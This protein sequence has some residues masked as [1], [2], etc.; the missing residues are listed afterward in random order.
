MIVSDVIY[1]WFR[2]K[3]VFWLDALLDF[4]DPDIT[5][6]SRGI[7]WKK[8]GDKYEIS[9]INKKNNRSKRLFFMFLKEDEGDKLLE[10]FV[11]LG[12]ATKNI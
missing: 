10:L 5:R 6:V 11:V 7:K 4:A 8:M 12:V 2:S 3:K 1:I 9:L